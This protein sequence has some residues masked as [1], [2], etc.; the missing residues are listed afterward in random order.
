MGRGENI[1]KS[2]VLELLTWWAGSSAGRAP[3]SHGGNSR[4]LLSEF[5]PRHVRF[6]DARLLDKFYNWL[7]DQV[8]EDTAKY[9]VNVIKKLGGWVKNSELREKQRKAIRKWIHFLSNEGL[10]DY[11]TKLAVLDHYRLQ[12]K[13]KHRTK[14]WI[15]DDIVRKVIAS[16]DGIHRLLLVLRAYSGARLSHIVY[17][18]NNWTPD[19]IVQHMNGA[20]EPRLFCNEL[21]C[22]YYVGI[23]E[24]GKRCDYIY[25][26]KSLL[27][28][29]EQTAP[30]GKPYR[31]FKD[32]YHHHG[33]EHGFLRSFFEQR[34]K[35][36][37]IDNK[38]P[39]DAVK[40]LMSRELSISG[41][42][43]DDTRRRAD[44]LYS[45]LIKHL[46]KV[47]ACL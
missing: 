43:Y 18:L 12:E 36:V 8:S 4:S 29:I 13:R 42:H 40:L 34:A 38:I 3:P 32:W 23:K 11:N 19:E 6:D 10:I 22:R 35:Q 28:E 25:F 21:F 41:T 14:K 30:L 5:Y 33:I 39:D 17:M 44:Q 46:E 31:Y 20:Y 26:P 9:Y 45:I 37:A 27:R 1:I 16:V 7:L 2:G 24:A 47:I 15:S